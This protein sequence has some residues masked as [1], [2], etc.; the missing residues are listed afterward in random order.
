[1]YSPDVVVRAVVVGVL[2][3]L[4]VVVVVPVAA[5]ASSVTVVIEMELV[6][7]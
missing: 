1:M 6:V 5:P 3:G 4:V 7:V 2:E